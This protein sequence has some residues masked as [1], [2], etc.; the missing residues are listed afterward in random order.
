[1]SS[2]S[3]SSSHSPD[4]LTS[5]GRPLPERV[6]WSIVEPDFMSAWGYPGGKFMPEHLEILGPT[7]SGKSYF[8]KTILQRRAEIRKSTIVILAT[9]PAD[10]TLQSLGW[11]I[12]T[13][14]PP[15][16]WKKDTKQVI[17][18]AKTKGLGAEGRARQR[19]SVEHLMDSIWQ[20]NANLILAF[21][22]IAYVEKDLGLNIH[23]ARFYREARGLGITLVSGT[24]RPQGVSR[25]IHS[26]ST[27]SVFFAPKDEDDA[28]RMAEVAGNRKY[29]LEVLDSLNRAEREFLLVH[30]LTNEAVITSITDT[31][32][33]KIKGLKND[34]K[35]NPVD[36]TV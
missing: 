17:Y 7:G 15:N 16:Q 23:T 4:E 20:P 26:E 5:E 11:P 8:E 36:R 18:W 1:M 34:P 35:R 2:T 33:V 25:Y 31:K 10:A 24:Q 32:N 6:P 27:W 9:K 29:Y 28:K 3:P 30:N 22:E 13:D 12:V 19:A 21:D 14:W